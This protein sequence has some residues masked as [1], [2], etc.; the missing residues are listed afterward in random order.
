MECPEV[1]QSSTNAECAAD[2]ACL[3]C[4][5]VRIRVWRS[6]NAVCAAGTMPAWAAMAFPIPVWKW[7]NVA[8]A[9]EAMPAWAVMESPNSGVF[10]D[11][12][13]V[14]GGDDACVGCD[15]EPNSGAEV[16]DCGVCEGDNTCLGCDECPTAGWNWMLAACVE[17][18]VPVSDATGSPIAVR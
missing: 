1:V 16:D 7:T 18:R 15:G 10:T 17:A 14:C 12:C 6:T 9:A 2:D 11:Q 8:F 5:G 3:G 13:G 4:D